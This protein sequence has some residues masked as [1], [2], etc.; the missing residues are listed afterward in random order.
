M[1]ESGDV[2]RE[3]NMKEGMKRRGRDKRSGGMCNEVL[4]VS[5]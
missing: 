2:V 4:P 1:E 3:R 5:H